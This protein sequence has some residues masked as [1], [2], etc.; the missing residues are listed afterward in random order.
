[1]DI[2]TLQRDLTYLAAQIEVAKGMARE[3]KAKRTWYHLDLTEAK[4]QGLMGYVGLSH[5]WDPTLMDD[6]RRQAEGSLLP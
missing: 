6:A 1:M 3:E 2:P 5:E 4:L